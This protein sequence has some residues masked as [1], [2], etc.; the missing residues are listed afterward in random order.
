MGKLA[1]RSV[2]NILRENLS[3]AT[4]FEFFQVDYPRFLDQTLEQLA[5]TYGI[6]LEVIEEAL[7][8]VQSSLP[9]FRYDFLELPVLIAY[10]KHTHHEYARAKMPH[11]RR[12]MERLGKEEL[13]EIFARFSRDLHKHMLL[14]EQVIFPFILNLVSLNEDF[15][16]Q[17]ALV[18]LESHSTEVLCASH[19]QDDDEMKELRECT[20]GF[21]F[22][23]EDPI[24]YQVLMTD[25]ARLEHDIH[26]HAHIED[27]ILFK[28]ARRE[29]N[30]LKERLW[31]EG[32][33]N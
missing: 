28:K 3:R 22:E 14:E 21:L 29:E 18:L 23:E 8:S 31:I 32:R 15:D 17:A 33:K 20:E 27:T 5:E 25:L 30:L 12:N 6:H 4:V 2:K 19:T 26:R 16:R 24:L 7:V 9:D 1:K 13:L 11:I 10:L